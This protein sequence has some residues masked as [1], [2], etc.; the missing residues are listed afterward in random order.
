MFIKVFPVGAFQCNCTII[1]DLKTGDAIVIDPG[2]EAERIIKELKSQNLT[3]RYILHTHA[4]LDHIGATRALKEGCG[5]QVCLHKDD[6][7]LYEN[8]AMQAELLRLPVDTRIV[9]V[10]HYLVHNDP[11]ECHADLRCTALHTPGHTPGSMCFL[12]ENLSLSD[13]KINLLFSG[14]TLFMGSVGRTDLWG[15]DHAQLIA[16]IKEKLLVL[17]GETI[18]VSG[19]GPQTTIGQELKINPFLQV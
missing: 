5:G 9:P 4:H 15:G 18:V 8:I 1:G 11:I 12:F 16:S 7:F 19:H 10:E 6:L 3:A 13:Q 17:P 14:D 2:D